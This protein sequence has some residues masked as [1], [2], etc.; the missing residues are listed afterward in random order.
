[1]VIDNIAR[2]LSPA[3]SGQ[4]AAGSRQPSATHNG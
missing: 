2:N 4:L 3:G 1:L